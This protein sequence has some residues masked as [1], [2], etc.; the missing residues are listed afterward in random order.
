M[1]YAA[2]TV[3]Y[4]WTKPVENKKI[5]LYREKRE[6]FDIIP[7]K[8]TSPSV[9]NGEYMVDTAKGDSYVIE[10][11]PE[12]INT[13]LTQEHIDKDFSGREVP[14][15]SE[16]PQRLPKGHGYDSMKDILINQYGYE[17]EDLASMSDD[18]IRSIYDDEVVNR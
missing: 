5:T 1:I 2:A 15:V 11:N 17:T 16:F 7:T 14:D 4:A 3:F 6:S 8:V 18:D 9:I 13:I 12:H 10:I